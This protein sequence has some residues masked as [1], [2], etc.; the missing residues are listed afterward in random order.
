MILLHDGCSIGYDLRD[1]EVVLDFMRSN[2]DEQFLI[3]TDERNIQIFESSVSSKQVRFQ[4]YPKCSFSK[5]KLHELVEDHA[6]NPDRFLS[7]SDLYLKVPDT[8]KLS[9]G[10]LKPSLKPYLN[11]P[12]RLV[13]TY[14]IFLDELARNYSNYTVVFSI[15]SGLK[16]L[17]DV[18]ITIDEQK[19]EGYRQTYPFE[20]IANTLKS[21][22]DSLIQEQIAVIPISAQYG[23]LRDIKQL[24][25]KVGEAISLKFPIKIFE[26]ID[27]SNRPEQQ[28]AFFRAVHERACDL[29]IP[30]VVFGNASTYQHLIIAATGGFHVSAV[31]LDSYDK[32][33]SRDGRPYWRELGNGE[34][35]G[36]K[37]FQQESD[38]PGNWESATKSMQ[39]HLKEGILSRI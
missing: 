15:V 11:P 34:L 16:P 22:Q 28:A 19:L 26:D 36:L 8:A 6:T 12:R 9:S 20:E 7:F 23:N 31:A 13:K 10:T 14:R 25:D 18:G 38:N 21:I 2:P 33:P 27:W 4:G 5:E 29:G 24:I 17:S 30:S 32:P 35:P 3:Y 39:K 37:V 1:F